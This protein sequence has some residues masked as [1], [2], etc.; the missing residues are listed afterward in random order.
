MLGKEGGDGGTGMLAA[1]L[2]CVTVVC[3][4]GCGSMC[5]LMC[6]SLHVYMRVY[7]AVTICVY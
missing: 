3:V 4:C 7:E 1:V 6:M 2:E 5:T